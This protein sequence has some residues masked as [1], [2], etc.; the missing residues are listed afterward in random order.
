[1]IFLSSGVARQHR[2]AC[3]DLIALFL[4]GFSNLRYYKHNKS[5]VL[6]HRREIKTPDIFFSRHFLTVAMI[7]IKCL[8]MHF[9]LYIFHTQSLFFKYLHY[10]WSYDTH[11]TKCTST[12]CAP[13]IYEAFRC[14]NLF[15][16]LLY[17]STEQ[18][19]CV[20]KD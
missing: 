7:G 19:A 18:K 20:K 6:V 2:K 1:M 10:F 5:D 15:L 3:D 12:S 8:H 4:Y 9:V 17:S 16:R 13:I 11:C 14:K